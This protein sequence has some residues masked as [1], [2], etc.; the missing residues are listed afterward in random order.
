MNYDKFTEINISGYENEACT[1]KI[2]TKKF[3]KSRTRRKL[4]FNCRLLSWCR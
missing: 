3:R 1:G 4:L 2:E